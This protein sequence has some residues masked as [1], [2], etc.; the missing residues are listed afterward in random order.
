MYSS[1]INGDNLVDYVTSINWTSDLAIEWQTFYNDASRITYYGR[2]TS[3][4]YKYYPEI[5][6]YVDL[7][8]E[9]CTAHGKASNSTDVSAQCGG[10]SGQGGGNSTLGGGNSTL[11]GGNSTLDG[12]SSASCQ[13]IFLA[14]LFLPFF[15]QIIT[16]M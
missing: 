15:I 8:Q 14:L 10:S 5:P 11:G 1:T 6:E 3:L 16:D 4:N 12:G 9:N 13:T 2:S 7:P